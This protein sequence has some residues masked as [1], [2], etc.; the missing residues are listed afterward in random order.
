MC[1]GLREDCTFAMFATQTLYA[2][3]R[4]GAAPF[5]A[6]ARAWQKVGV[7]QG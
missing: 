3:E 6:L 2:A 7:L 4:Y 5:D 1:T